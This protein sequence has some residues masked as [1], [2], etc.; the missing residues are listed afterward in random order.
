[1]S[2][3]NTSKKWI[4]TLGLI[5]ITFLASI[6]Y[7]FLGM[8]PEEVST[9]SFL[10]VTNLV[11]LVILGLTRMKKLRLMKQSTIKKG[12]ILAVLNTA[13]NF[14]VIL[15]SRNV[16]SV[17]IASVMSMY[18]IFITPIMVLLK[19]RVNIL[20]GIASGIAIIALILMFGADIEVIASSPNVVFLIVA[21]V[22]FAI[23]VICISIYGEDED[24][25]TLT[26]SQ[27]LFG[28]ILSLG[29]W[30]VEAS[31]GLA[32][33]HLPMNMDFWLSALFIGIFIRALYGII[34]ISCQKNV[35][36]INASLIFSSEILIVILTE[37]IMST[38]LHRTYVPA[39]GYQ[40]IGCFLFVIATLFLD[41]G[42]M[43]KLGCIDEEI[44][45]DEEDRGLRKRISVSRKFMMMIVSFSM[46]VL[47][48]STIICISAI[49][50]IRDAAVDSSES[51]GKYA[52]VSSQEAL[53]VELEMEIS[54]TAESKAKLAEEKLEAYSDSVQYA[55]S[56][57]ETL[58]NHPSSYERTEAMYP[59][60]EN[61]GQWTMQRTLQD[62]KVLYKDVK[63]ENGLLGNMV[64]VFAPIV[65]QKPEISTIYIGTERGLL[66]SYDPFSDLASTGGEVY[67]NFKDSEWYKLG[68]ENGKC[69]YTKTYQ[70]AAGRGLTIT[71]VSPFYNE[72]G[73]FQGC[74]A[75]DILMEDLNNSMIND[76]LS[77]HQEA[78][79]I[80]ASGDII[81]SKRVDPLAEQ[82]SNIY[83]EDADSNVGKVAD[84]I[85][86]NKKGVTQTGD[87]EDAMYVAYST[88]ETTG[89][90]LCISSP[91][92]Y[93]TAPALKIY[94]SIEDNTADVVTMVLKGVLNI[95][96]NCLILT[97]IVLIVITFSVG[98][99][100]RKITDPLLQL[101]RDVNTI[102]KGDLNQR[103]LVDTNDEIGLLAKSFNN[104]TES[105]QRYIED[106]TEATVKEERMAS[107]LNLAATIQESSLQKDFPDSE[108]F[109]LFATMCPAKEVGGDFYDFFQIDDTHLGLVIADV[110]GKGVPAAL[111]MMKSKTLL[112]NQCMELLSPAEV[113]RRVNNQLCD[114]NEA[115][116]FVTVW[117]GIIDLTT[118]IMK[119]ANA[120]HE[121]PVK[122][123]AQGEYELIKD[124]HGLVLGGMEGVR[125]KEYEIEFQDGDRLFVYT[126][127]VAEATNT[128]N[129]LYGVERMLMALNRHKE[130]TPK[131]L[132][133]S[134]R[135]EVDVFVGE[136]P[137]FDDITMLC[138]EFK[139]RTKTDKDRE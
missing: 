39:T 80:A 57:A 34:Q 25:Q 111:F 85:L 63:D 72:A 22:I 43:R 132:L 110:S 83:D 92:S 54:S 60:P 45:E 104:M 18:F 50:H 108:Y 47:L 102:S 128:E 133:G 71:C 94:E 62:E 69:S 3:V 79:L 12:F 55:V 61:G 134:I 51:L 97:A 27:M 10:F 135:E 9:F 86:S 7:I 131:T 93:I 58:I 77:P 24:S 32:V 5:F 84:I 41:E 49:Q 23:Y 53:K 124:K 137:Q 99:I 78:E 95:I 112:K 82:M 11:G 68:K 100:S 70:D 15:G 116:M 42:I 138:F 126:D 81:A 16:D 64:N 122:K 120:G 66:V 136:A 101:Q 88:I 76:N 21:D 46:G 89:W 118:G 105:L 59:I 106:L 90:V 125:F 65:E 115:E 31:A 74:I 113:L 38:L 56:Y 13:M 30:I 4:S 8:V 29:G 96:R 73:E 36:A 123:A 98:R 109:G 117:L 67:Y 127:G 14:F 20:S 37:P 28:A 35:P 6:Q 139:Q 87:D 129:E 119:A 75:I 52:A 40:I 44:Q 2:G 121:Y 33:F 48:V 114:G 103:T 107:E 91:V 19:K 26:L 130:E 17:I 1:M